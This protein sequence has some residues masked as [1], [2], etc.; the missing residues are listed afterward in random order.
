M[1]L[2]RARGPQT[3]N[4]HRVY[5]IARNGSFGS[6]EMKSGRFSAIVAGSHPLC[7]ARI[8][9]PCVEQRHVLVRS[10]ELDDGCPLLSILDLHTS[11]GF[12]LSDGSSQR[13]IDATGPVVVCIGGYAIVALPS[14]ASHDEEMPAPVTEHRGESPY[15]IAAPRS[16]LADLPPAAQALADVPVKSVSRITLLPNIVD[17]ASTSSPSKNDGEI[18]ELT[19]TGGRG[20]RLIRLSGLDLRR[21]V[22]VG[23]SLNCDPVLRAIVDMGIS[24]GHLLLMKDRNGV[25]GFDLASTQGSFTFGKRMRAIEMSDHGTTVTIGAVTPITLFWRRA[26]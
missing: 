21:G 3:T 16:V 6:C 17:F 19:M 15:R 7:D 25:V 20:S 8:D 23:R 13:S 14:G 24:R 9:D 11:T 2:E 26:Y 12:F 22:L 4:G 10:S 1:Q 5:W 18:Y